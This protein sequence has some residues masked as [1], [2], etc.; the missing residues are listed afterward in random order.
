VIQEEREGNNM[1]GKHF[2]ISFAPVLSRDGTLVFRIVSIN[3]SKL[4]FAFFESFKRRL[5]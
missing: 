2:S 1:E 5:D 3:N 4:F